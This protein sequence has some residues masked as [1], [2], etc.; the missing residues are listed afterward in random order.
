M[1]E[2]A[3]GAPARKRLMIVDDAALMRTVIRNL[4]NSDPRYDVAATCSNGQIG[5]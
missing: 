1:P 3:K 4:L 2:V 5:L